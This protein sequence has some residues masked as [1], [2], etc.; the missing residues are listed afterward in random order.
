MKTNLGKLAVLVVGLLLAFSGGAQPVT[1]IAG[2]QSHSLFLK[3]DGSL[4]A[5]GYNYFGQLG[6][7]NYDTASPYGTN[8]P[9]QLVTSN[10]TA[11]TAGGG[12]SLFLKS[13]GSLWAMGDNRYGQLGDGIFISSAPYGVN[14]PEQIVANGITNI[15][16]GG[17]YNLILKSDGSLWAMGANN[18]GQLGDGTFIPTFPYGVNLPE[19]I[20]AN[21]VTNIAAGGSHSL[22]V[23]SDGGL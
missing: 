17:A 21:G 12:H 20:V 1:K 13:D 18:Y 8:Q 6:D 7:G 3:S 15:A 19:Q 14:V 5:M 10:I 23:K 9:Q 2:G 22:F 16:A 4:S 11:I